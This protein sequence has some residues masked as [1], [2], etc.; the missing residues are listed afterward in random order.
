MAEEEGNADEARAL[1]KRSHDVLNAIA[2]KGKHVSPQDM[3]ALAILK[4]KA[5]LE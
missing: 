4:R 5:G 3:K 1:Y 2:A